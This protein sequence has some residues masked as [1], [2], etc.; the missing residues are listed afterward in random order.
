M[1]SRKTPAEAFHDPARRKVGRIGIGV[2][3]P[4]DALLESEPPA[5]T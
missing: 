1:K 5:S 2:L 4:N 3:S